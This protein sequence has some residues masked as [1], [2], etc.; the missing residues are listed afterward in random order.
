M[1]CLPARL[2]ALSMLAPLSLPAQT[3]QVIQTT[4]DGSSLLA[5][6]QIAFTP[7]NSPAKIHIVIDPSQRFQTID[8]FGASLTDS[9]AAIF[10]GLS[11]MQRDEV[12]RELFAPDGPLGLTLLRQP[13]GASDFSAHGDYSYDDPPGNRPD[14]ELTSFSTAPDDAYLFPLL[15]E[16]EHLNPQLRVLTLPWSAPAWM[17]SNQSM[18]AG[19]L[20]SSN[21][22]VYAHY[23]ARTI[24]AYAAHGV[25][26]FALSLQNEPLNENASYPTQRMPPEQEFQLAAALQPLLSQA[27]RTPLLLGYEHN[28]DNL[29]YPA[30]L[31]SMDAA[32][33]TPFF[34]GISFHCYAGDASAQSRLQ[35]ADPQVGIWF[36]ECS[37]TN[38]T[39]FADS[40]LW[41]AHHLLMGALQH[42]ARSLLLWNVVL[43]PQGGPHNGGCG[44]CRPLLTVESHA[45]AVRRT[46]DF[47][48]LAQLAPFIHPGAT[49]I[50]AAVNGTQ[51]I[52]A[53]AFLNLDSTKVAVVFN[54][55]PSAKQIA[56]QNESGVASYQ[57]PPRSVV[58]F[59]WGTA[60]PALEEGTYR[61]GMPDH[62]AALEASRNSDAPVW[63]PLSASPNQ[64]WTL[65][66]LRDGRFE[67]RN[68][69]TAQALVVSA[70]GRWQTLTLDGSHVA[71]LLLLPQPG[72]F[73]LD[74]GKHQCSAV[75]HAGDPLDAAAPMALMAPAS[76]MQTLSSSI[77]SH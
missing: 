60:V 69:A 33:A 72:G 70:Q 66:R 55:S 16:A 14:P 7:N 50:G 52:S 64:L 12:M 44:N 37:G 51:D 61:L 18:H 71:E 29:A 3:I 77:A 35:Q 40:F 25:P 38:G 59:T 30:K 27:G 24:E 67:L 47:Y 11:P 73:C 10:A 63:S 34:A 39:T 4:A 9:S 17:K 76:G 23:L 46:V 15:R 32:S 13:I 2:F 74:E 54:E 31:L 26:V 21:L 5:R 28:W 62:A 8:G 22:N 75:L 49:R 42:D 20:K 1:F 43:N 53:E 19:M 57:V 58:T 65:R 36:T 41:N 56:L 48:V 68:L 45:G 6:Q